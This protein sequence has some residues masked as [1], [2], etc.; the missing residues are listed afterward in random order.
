MRKEIYYRQ[1]VL[2]RGNTTTVSWIPEKYAETGKYLKLKN[3]NGEW[4][5]GW[6]V[7]SA[8]TAKVEESFLPDSHQQIKDH[9]KRTGDSLPKKST[10]GS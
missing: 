8:S 2:E 3:E 4:V 1:C 7:K 6:V 5:D 9:K 10:N